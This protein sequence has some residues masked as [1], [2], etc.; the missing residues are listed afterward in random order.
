MQT[1]DLENVGQ[2]LLSLIPWGKE[3]HIF[4]STGVVLITNRNEN[5]IQIT[6]GGAEAK[7]PQEEVTIYPDGRLVKTANAEMAAVSYE[8]KVALVGLC[9][10]LESQATIC[11]PMR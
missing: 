8:D 3:Q 11:W 2:R 5:S 10:L 9:E 7:E 1:T 6:M 4:P